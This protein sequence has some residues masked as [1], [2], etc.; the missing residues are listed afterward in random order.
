[1]RRILHDFYNPVCIEIL[2]NTVPA[3]GPDSRLIIC[4]M[5]IPQPVEVN[6]PAQ[7]YWMDFSLM[8][9]SGKEKTLKEFTDIFDEVG[10]ELVK[11]YPSNIGETVM[12]ETRLKRA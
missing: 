5:L 8:I 9:I 4:D 11:V 10:L 3:M 7:P 12:L 1:M 2:K 6:G